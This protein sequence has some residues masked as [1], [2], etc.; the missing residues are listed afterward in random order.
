MKKPSNKAIAIYLIWGL[1]NF[2]LLLQYT[3]KY[4]NHWFYPSRGLD[5]T[6]YYDITEFAFYM[7]APILIYYSIRLFKSKDTTDN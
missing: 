5:D 6:K 4:A 1:I 7:V 2:A 3:D